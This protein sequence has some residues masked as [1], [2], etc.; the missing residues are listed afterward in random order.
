MEAIVVLAIAGLIVVGLYRAVRRRSGRT[1]TGS[2]EKDVQ[3]NSST[4]ERDA[5]ESEGQIKVR[6]NAAAERARQLF[7]NATAV[8][9][10]DPDEAVRLFRKAKEQAALCGMDHGIDVFVRLP[11]YL[12]EAG[13]SEEG[14]RELNDLLTNGYPN[15]IEGN[16]AR[17][18]M[19]SAVLDRMRIFLQREKRF[20][21][22]VL[23]GVLAIIHDIKAV[24]TEWPE[25][26]RFRDTKLVEPASNAMTK[27]T[28]KHRLAEEQRRRKDRQRDLEN[29][30]LLQHE[31][32]LD[33]QLTKLLRRAKL[34][35]RHD[36][37]LSVLCEWANAQPGAD[38]SKFEQRFSQALGLDPQLSGLN[39]Q[40]QLTQW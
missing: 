3:G 4:K 23:F 32:R 38:D 26:R 11:R 34:L 19:Q 35:E 10:K 29:A 28:E 31:D 21:S 6:T 37:A 13:R 5:Q 15:M 7:R 33:E 16:R 22:A 20:A 1:G 12:Q 39:G 30:K 24:L 25:A 9:A 40:A 27:R 36:E 8:S 18:L 17:R 14:W 2:G